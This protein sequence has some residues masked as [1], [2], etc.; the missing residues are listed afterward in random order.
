MKSIDRPEPVVKSIHRPERGA[1]P[2]ALG[3]A[4]KEHPRHPGLLRLR[5]SLVARASGLGSSVLDAAKKKVM[6]FLVSGV[7]QASTLG[8][9]P[10]DEEDEEGICVEE[11]EKVLDL[12][13]QEYELCLSLVSVE[14]TW[15]GVMGVLRKGGPCGP[16][17]SSLNL[18]KFNTTSRIIL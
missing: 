5:L 12:K 10:Q 3:L 4:L 7:V 15:Q 1:F 9:V 16:C 13:S 6:D 8:R 18:G 14:P 11:P 2:Q 17:G